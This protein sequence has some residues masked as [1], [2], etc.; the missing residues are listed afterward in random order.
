[1]RWCLLGVL[2]CWS[3]A[4]QTGKHHSTCCDE[5]G[6]IGDRFC[7]VGGLS[8]SCT[9]SVWGHHVVIIRMA[10]QALGVGERHVASAHA[11]LDAWIGGGT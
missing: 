1:M 9:R 2:F 8:I 4:A 5:G 6:C 11:T 7:V 3:T 10:S